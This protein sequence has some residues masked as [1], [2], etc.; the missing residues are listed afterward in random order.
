MTFPEPATIDKS[1]KGFRKGT[2]RSEGPMGKH[3][4]GIFT[5]F[6]HGV[7]NFHDVLVACLFDPVAGYCGHSPT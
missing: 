4:N 1:E 6:R 2:R 5:V 7:M 3:N